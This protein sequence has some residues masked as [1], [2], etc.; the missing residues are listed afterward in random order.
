[1]HNLINLLVP[2]GVP[3]SE[4]CPLEEVWGHFEDALSVIILTV[5]QP[6]ILNYSLK[7]KLPSVLEMT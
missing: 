6:V 4:L 1:M 2:D 7:L 5:S 3:D